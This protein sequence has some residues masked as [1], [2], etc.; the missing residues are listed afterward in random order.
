MYIKSNFFLR[1]LVNR[2]IENNNE[3]SKILASFSDV[4][5]HL[6]FEDFPINDKSFL[7]NI[8]HDGFLE[9][10]FFGNLASLDFEI[11]D[12]DICIYVS[13]QYFR[14]RFADFVFE[15]TVSDEKRTVK[16]FT[17]RGLKIE[18]PVN[19]V[20]A[21]SPLV[22]LL[23]ESFSPLLSNCKKS[24]FSR[25]IRNI[26]H[27]VLEKEKLIVKN[28]DFEKHIKKLRNLRNKISFVDNRI[29]ELKNS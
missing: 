8:D 9:N 12:R 5:I 19:T 29:D 7:I 4:K 2:K 25:M 23:I 10:V 1:D 6:T 22:S 28:D 16:S 11:S 27:K 24:T 17:G 18:G 26:S 15:T 20:Q 21:L 13:N 14:D 3:L